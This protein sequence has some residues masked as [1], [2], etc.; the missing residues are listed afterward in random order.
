MVSKY[1]NGDVNDQVLT[2]KN[3]ES[4]SPGKTNDVIAAHSVLHFERRSSGTRI[5][6]YKVSAAFAFAILLRRRKPSGSLP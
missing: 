5:I 1:G 3:E 6:E 4:L 2:V